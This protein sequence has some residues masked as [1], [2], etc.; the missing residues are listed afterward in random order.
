MKEY[1][2]EDSCVLYILFEVFD[3]RV[4]EVEF[5]LESRVRLDFVSGFYFFMWFFW[6][7]FYF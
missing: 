6:V 4:G 1:T 3:V 7:D 2:G 5:I